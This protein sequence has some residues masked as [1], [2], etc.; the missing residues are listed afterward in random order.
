MQGQLSVQAYGTDQQ[1]QPGPLTEVTKFTVTGVPVP[2]LMSAGS[3]SFLV[4]GYQW[5]QGSQPVALVNGA[6][7][8]VAVSGTQVLYP[9]YCPGYLVGPQA[10]MNGPGSATV[11]SYGY[12]QYNSC[13]FATYNLSAP[14][15]APVLNA[16]Y[17]GAASY[18]YFNILV[19]QVVVTAAQGG[20]VQLPVSFTSALGYA[21]PVQ[22]GV[23]TPS[24]I[25][26]SWDVSALALDG[27]NGASANLTLAVDPGLARGTYGVFIPGGTYAGNAG[28]FFV[29][30][31]PNTVPDFVL[32]AITPVS[33]A[34]GQAVSFSA[35]VVPVAGFGGA[36][37]VSSPGVAGAVGLT[38]APNTTGALTGSGQVVTGT[39][40]TFASTPSCGQ[41]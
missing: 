5:A 34:A 20:S 36:V 22:L 9:Q 4:P 18:A 16:V 37:T 31:T 35:R 1:G 40:A 28:Y 3:S 26:A 41:P 8:P 7:G 38:F 10:S 29:T 19:P 23:V 13:L 24:G 15:L 6:V 33:V 27:V 21:G 32:S 25:S 11:V 12:V 39:V 14:G 2:M 17:Y 30:V